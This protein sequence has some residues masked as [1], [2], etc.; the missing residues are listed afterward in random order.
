M[1][2][3][4]GLGGDASRILLL[5]SEGVPLDR[6]TATFAYV[7]LAE[8]PAIVLL[9]ASATPAMTA[10]AG[11]SKTAFTVVVALVAVAAIAAW[12]G[13]GRVRARIDGLV[14]QTRHLRIGRRAMAGSVFYATLTQIETVARQIVVA[15]ACGLRL[16]VQQSATVVAL[17]IVGGLVPTVGSLGTIDGSM[18]AGLMLFGADAHTAVAITLIERLISYG[19]STAAGA[20]ALTY[21]GGRGILRAAGALD[22]RRIAEES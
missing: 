13:R 17:S 1:T 22:T 16:T 10:L 20:A 7:R 14:E 5:R 3:T 8:M 15:A 4:T 12:L 11:R 9:V 18:V 21:L 6:G 19:V 2:P